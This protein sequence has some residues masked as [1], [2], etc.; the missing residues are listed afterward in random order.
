MAEPSF[1]QRLAATIQAELGILSD[2]QELVVAN[3]IDREYATAQGKLPGFALEHT[4]LVR[5]GGR[6][7]REELFDALCGAC[8]LPREGMTHPMQR[9]VSVALT[10][11]MAVMP[12]LTTNEIIIRARE[13]RR[14]HPTW[15]L[16]P[17]SLAKHWGTC[18]TRESERGLLDE[19]AGWRQKHH[20]IFPPEQTGATGEMFSRN[21]WEKIGRVYQEKII[22]FMLQLQPRP[23]SLPHAD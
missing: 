12:K 1:G 15:E 21:P 19:P 7:Q 11:I 20:L 16:T 5:Q 14:K 2:D 3:L 6:K 9:A 10:A 23:A 4:S 13:Y 22:R 17:N 8:G 18:A